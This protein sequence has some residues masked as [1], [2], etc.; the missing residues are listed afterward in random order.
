MDEATSKFW[1]DLE[2]APVGAILQ[3]PHGNK[4]EKLSGCGYKIHVTLEGER[5][6]Q[7]RIMSHPQA[8]VR[9]KCGGLMYEL[10]RLPSGVRALQCAE[11]GCFDRRVISP[12]SADANL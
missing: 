3:H 1:D 8:D 9:C 7:Q 4:F 6:L 2:E 11:I 12:E 10:V 5:N